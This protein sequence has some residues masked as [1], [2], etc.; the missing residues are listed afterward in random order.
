MI[1]LPEINR[2]DFLVNRKFPDLITAKAIIFNS[3]KQNE[4]SRTPKVLETWKNAANYEKELSKLSKSEVKKLYDDEKTKINVEKEEASFFNQPHASADFEYWSKMADWTLDESIALSFGENPK[5]VSLESLKKSI[6]HVSPFLAE[7]INLYELAQRAIKWNKLFDP[8]LPMY[9]ISWVEENDIAFPDE[10]VAKA[11]LR[12]KNWCDWRKMYEEQLEKRNAGVDNFNQIL[13][14]K[15]NIIETL[16]N[17]KPDEK[18]LQTKERE[19][20]LKMIIGMAVSGYCYD[21]TATRS[22][23]PKEIVDDLDL[24]GI[25]I[26]VDT[27]R[28]WLKEASELL[29]QDALDNDN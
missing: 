5:I 12:N 13:S 27:V 22:S 20:L 19:S 7:Y 11:A 24:R 18:S 2:I 16:Q 6:L 4:K 1:K 15:N 23:T 14:Q 26:D 8:M 10:L 3:P 21:P 28:K 25:S 17:Q 9:F 29:P